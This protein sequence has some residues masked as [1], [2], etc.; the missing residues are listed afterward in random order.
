MKKTTLCI[1]NYIKLACSDIN[2]TAEKG[3]QKGEQDN[4]YQKRSEDRE[5]T[6]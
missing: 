3:E 1:K 5:K 6:R 4:L 2:V